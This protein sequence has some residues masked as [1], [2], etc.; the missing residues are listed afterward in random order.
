M[1]T[2]LFSCVSRPTPLTCSI[3]C[4][5]SRAG[6]FTR[7]QPP[8]LS[9]LCS[10]QGRGLHMDGAHLQAKAGKAKSQPTLRAGAPG[11]NGVIGAALTLTASGGI[12]YI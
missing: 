3:A 11:N 6:P 1:R 12:R 2:R 5:Q 9:R 10:L 7:I 8:T 4:R